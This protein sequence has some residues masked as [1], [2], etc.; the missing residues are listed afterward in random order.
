MTD[1]L[2]F[3]LRTLAVGCVYLLTNRAT[4][5]FPGSEIAKPS[6][7]VVV[8]LTARG[9][10]RDGDR[11]YFPFSVYWGAWHEAVVPVLK[12]KDVQ[13]IVRDNPSLRVQQNAYLL[14]HGQVDVLIEKIEWYLRRSLC[15]AGYIPCDQQETETLPG[16]CPPAPTEIN[17]T[18][19]GPTGP[20]VNT[21]NHPDGT[22]KL[23]YKIVDAG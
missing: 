12:D 21:V 15:A 5:E 16:S 17:Y 9:L 1:P 11:V 13:V 23:T 10:F 2:H 14:S 20:D 7:R 3:H 22:P 4:L 6:D 18:P 19:T 8:N